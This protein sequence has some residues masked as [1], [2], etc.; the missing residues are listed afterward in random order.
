MSKLEEFKSV[1]PENWNLDTDN[2]FLEALTDSTEVTY[3][4]IK[5][6][7]E[8]LRELE[9]NTENC[10]IQL[11]HAVNWMTSL[12]YTKFILNKVQPTVNGSESKIIEEPTP[13]V[14][15]NKVEK[16]RKALA[17]AIEDLNLT[18]VK[19]DEGS[20]KKVD[21]STVE[22]TMAGGA[23]YVTPE[24]KGRMPFLIGSKEFR[25]SLYMGLA[26][27]NEGLTQDKLNDHAEEGKES[28]ENPS[29][30]AESIQVDPGRAAVA[31]G[32]AVEEN[33][34]SKRTGLNDLSSLM[35]G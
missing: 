5:E 20:G 32:Q 14:A 26:V 7:L 8:S 3:S 17:I 13:I 35:Q 11:K 21:E 2:R 27:S 30:K 28:S 4:G 1:K 15:E 6:V 9:R 34:S 12:T 33:K 31:M 16:Y 29:N 10:Y 18:N 25:S 24:L 23:N 19:P 22:H